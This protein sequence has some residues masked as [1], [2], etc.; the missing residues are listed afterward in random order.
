MEYWVD[1]AFEYVLYL[2]SN[3]RVILDRWMSVANAIQQKHKTVVYPANANFHTPA[4]LQAINEDTEL[5]KIIGESP[6]I[7]ESIIVYMA[8]DALSGRNANV[9][10]IPRYEVSRMNSHTIEITSFGCAF[11]KENHVRNFNQDAILRFENGEYIITL[12]YHKS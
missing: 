5:C 7:P 2:N 9:F 10:T 6:A 4:L 8:G 3:D 11:I 12:S 1:R